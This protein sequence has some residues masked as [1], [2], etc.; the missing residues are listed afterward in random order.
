MKTESKTLDD[1]WGLMATVLAAGNS[2]SRRP[3]GSV[4]SAPVITGSCWETVLA[5]SARVLNCHVTKD[6]PGLHVGCVYVEPVP[7]KDM[8]RGTQILEGCQDVSNGEIRLA[9]NNFG[10]EPLF[11]PHLER[12]LWAVPSPRW[13][14][15][16]LKLKIPLSQSMCLRLYRSR[17]PQ[18]LQMFVLSQ[19]RKGPCSLSCPTTT[20]LGLVVVPKM[21]VIYPKGLTLR[22]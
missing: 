6:V 17:H 15:L 5:E 2:V 14:G 18:K 4:G 9:V 20:T 19:L 10:R 8:L 1:S 16:M 22:E 11:I 21:I 7:L 12:L 13:V 3:T